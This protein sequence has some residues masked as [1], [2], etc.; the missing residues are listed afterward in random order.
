MGY[1]YNKN[2]SVIIEVLIWLGRKSSCSFLFHTPIE[3]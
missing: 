2:C 3:I 1:V